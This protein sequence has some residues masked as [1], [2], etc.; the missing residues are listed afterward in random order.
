MHDFASVQLTNK[1]YKNLNYMKNYWIVH[2]DRMFIIIII[3]NKIKY[4]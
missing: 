1:K 4:F 3:F 2:N